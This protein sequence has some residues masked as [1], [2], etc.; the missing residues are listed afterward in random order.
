MFTGYGSELV[1]A[2][3][4]EAGLDGYMRKNSDSRVYSDLASLIRR[5]VE[6]RR[7]PP[8]STIHT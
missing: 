6:A 8:S 2:A 5:L 4:I 7:D 3:G 1:A